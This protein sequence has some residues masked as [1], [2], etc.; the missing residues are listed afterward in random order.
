VIARMNIGGPAHHVALLSGRLD[1]E[2]YEALLV[3]G[4]LGAGEASSEGL[5]RRYGA[6]M[7]VLPSL[8]PAIDPV[9]DLRSLRALAAVVRGFRPDIVHTHTAKAGALG[10]AAALVAGGRRPAIVHTYHGH[11][12]EGYF[13]PA[14]TAGYRAVE[15][16][17]ARFSDSL[18]GVSQA[19][20]DDLVRLRVAP[21]ERFTVVPLGL[22]LDRF[23]AL[24]PPRERE[25]VTA[26]YAGR[27]VPIK[28]VDLL[29][30]ALARARAGGAP[31]RLVVLGDGELRPELERLAAGLGIAAHVDFLGYRDDVAPYL[32]G[33][34]MAVL[35]SANE[36]TPVALIEAAA[37]GRPSV[38]T[39]V[40]GVEDVVAPGTGRLVASGDDEA[41]AGALAELA[42]DRS[43]RL[44]LGERARAHVRERFA[45]E[46][47]LADVDRLYTALLAARDRHGS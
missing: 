41:L 13:G 44:E 21:R 20:V 39:R 7:H 46:R 3:T 2:R 9:A 4:R 29:L 6:R 5:A 25:E 35:S 24:G 47:L 38:G 18:V 12:L 30:R 1:P 31:L 36:G 42:G 11:V 32:A 43:L 27:L 22:E 14:V 26:L 8:S 16:G 45:Q 34:D 19:T 37:A 10:R 28:Q 15:R 23:L 17:L 33:A 40:G